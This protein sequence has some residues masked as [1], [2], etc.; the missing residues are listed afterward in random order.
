MIEIEEAITLEEDQFL[1]LPEEVIINIFKYVDISN[2]ASISL[3]CSKFYEMLCVLER[4]QFPLDL[5]YQQ[6]SS[7]SCGAKFLKSIFPDL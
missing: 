5:N 4:D 6:V 2:R 1:T 3:V 7:S